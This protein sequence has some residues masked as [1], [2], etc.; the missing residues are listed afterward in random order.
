[1]QPDKF[2]LIDQEERGREFGLGKGWTETTGPYVV[3]GQSRTKYIQLDQA[4]AE[5]EPLRKM[6]QEAR[7]GKF[8]VLIMTEFDRLREMLDQVFRTLAMYHVQL[9]SLH[10]YFEP[11]SPEEYNIYH[12]D[13][14]VMS[15]AMSQTMSRLEI[16]R[17]RRKWFENMP[18][19]IT[20]LGLPATSLSYGYRK[21]ADQKHNRKAIPEPDP[22]IT[23]HVIAVKN[24]LLA[25][26]STSELVKYL[27]DHHV[28]PPRGEK[29]YRQTVRDILRNPFYAGIVRFGVSKVYIDPVTET[30][31]RNRR[32]PASQVREN[33]GKHKPLWD[34]NTLQLIQ[35]EFRR[36]AN[37]Y[38]GRVN[39]EF[40]GLVICGICKRSMWRHGNGPRGEHRLIWRCSSTGSAKGHNSWFH[41]ELR[42]KII[43]ELSRRLPPYLDQQS[44]AR[45]APKDGTQDA[46]DRLAELETRLERLEEAYLAG[47]WD[48]DRYT[49]RK[50]SLDEEI[51][52]AQKTID[53][54]AHRENIHR[55]WVN[56]LRNMKELHN[57]PKF[58]DETDPVEINRKLH[59]VL[60]AIVV[61]ENIELVF[62]P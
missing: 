45:S 27:E 49:K 4:A 18:R 22:I 37:N 21:P 58:F 8:N 26:H 46:H 34:V 42:E 31:K 14:I 35:A 41:K 53:G 40:T 52:D 19:R 57:I 33:F 48:L 17:T 32:I 20:D 9:V 6:L 43:D 28:P 24:M 15:I 62:K 59:I 25:G 47:K 44:A 50:E 60:Q 54:A 10:Q 12:A 11:M 23:H 5:I 2:S 39:N 1:M 51:A 7:A 13:T 3:R 55:V 30:R 38:R 29:W 56:E 61:G 36:R 16:S